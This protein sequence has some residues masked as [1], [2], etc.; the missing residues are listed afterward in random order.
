[1]NEL[2]NKPD[3]IVE[4]DGEYFMDGRHV[5]AIIGKEF[6]KIIR[7]LKTVILMEQQPEMVHHQDHADSINLFSIKGVICIKDERGYIK[8]ALINEHYCRLLEMYG[9]FKAVIRMNREWEA[10]R[11]YIVKQRQQPQLPVSVEVKQL[12]HELTLANKQLK[13]EERRKK[14]EDKLR[15][16][17][18][19]D[20]TRLTKENE[21]LRNNGEIQRLTKEN[22]E[23]RKQINPLVN[24]LLQIAIKENE[25]LRNLIKTAYEGL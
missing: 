17:V 22:E 16:Q 14:A 23:L 4:K 19:K 9:D 20:L 21:E 10:M 1:M 3:Y 12:K 11:E 25:R 7:D 5:A 13:F 15:E 6:K 24:D 18:F 2:M 8:D